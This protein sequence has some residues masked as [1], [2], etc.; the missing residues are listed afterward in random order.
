MTETEERRKE[1]SELRRARLKFRM[2]QLR[3]Q[4][5]IF[6]KSTYGKVGFWII[7][8]F[9][10][11]AIL[12]PVLEVHH[13]ALTWEAPPIDTLSPTLSAHANI[14]TPA[15]YN[16]TPLVPTSSAL[17]A[18]GANDVYTVTSSGQ[19]IAVSLGSAHNY[20][21]NSKISLFNVSF[22]SGS[23]VM[24]VTAFPLEQGLSVAGVLL[25]HNYMIVATSNGNISFSKLA[26][27]GETV[28]SGNLT[29][30][31]PQTL[32]LSSQLV[33]MPIS[34]S[35]PVGGTKVPSTLP[36][37]STSSNLYDA[38]L[39]SNVGNIVAIT[40]NATGYYLVDITDS[41]LSVVWEHKLASSAVP[42]GF[43]FMGSFY[44]SA[45]NQM[46]I[47]TQGD[48]ISSY[49]LLT[50]Q[51]AWSHNETSKFAG[52]S[53]IPDSAQIAPSSNNVIF[54]VMHNGTGSNLNAFYESNGTAFSVFS[55]SQPITAISSSEG[56]SGFPSSVLAIAG[57]NAYVLNGP[58]SVASGGNVTLATSYGNYVSNPVYVS[59]LGEYIIASQHGGVYALSASLG[60]TPFNWGD[61]SGAGA[62]NSI[63]SLI[64]INDANTAQQG[65]SF[66]S[67]T[68]SVIVYGAHGTNRNPVPPELHTPSGTTLL[69]GT[70]TRG[71]DVWSQF[72]ASFAPDWAVGI[73][74]GLITMGIALL[75]GMMIGYY[76]GFISVALDTFSLVIY[77]IPGLALLIA[78]TSVL[79][80]SFFNL[81]WILSF[82]AWPFTT[83]TI[84][85]IIRS[86]RTRTFVDAATVSG[87]STMHI[88]RR[89]MLPN[90]T[91]L[92]IY[93]T[94]VSIS[95]AVTGIALL[96][97]L[98]VAP[99]T[100]LTWGAM[101]N[102]LQG[103][104]FAAAA[105]PWWIM[106]PAI[107]L[108]LFVMAFI[109]LSR[110]VDE[111]VN[112]R[113]RRR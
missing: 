113:I 38:S 70:S 89:H 94:A 93:L 43:N 99:T 9:A 67:S 72:I 33:F 53:Y 11:I 42:T 104:F 32:N 60:K 105:A 82:I 63:S 64:L 97:F 20:A 14:V 21:V 22:P 10:V 73:S 1:I 49:H 50:G 39:Q 41:P 25:F 26:W 30:S 79:S 46:I 45:T 88:L 103:D 19:V 68:G 77:L 106:P 3:K 100:I 87:A 24:G 48:T 7:V 59:S 78:L 83:F 17:S 71:S 69:L 86:L 5:K 76:R 56:F 90:I 80:P 52:I 58:N 62:S 84:L 66:I 81:I 57:N 54:E 101:L 31:T 112:P 91:P 74:V 34:T 4:W 23:R 37:L 15:V 55:T 109:F 27:T 92:L 96:Q 51:Q 110:G 44:P 65:V 111:L 95:G 13:D 8:V 6:Y 40:H 2:T 75:L 28:G 85:G 29:A 18:S 47:V 102:P 108:T 16:G 61:V 36:L 12:S 107:A 98:G 35:A